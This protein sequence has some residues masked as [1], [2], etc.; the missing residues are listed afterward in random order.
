MKLFSSEQVRSLDQKTASQEQ[1]SSSILMEHAGLEAAGT[2][3]EVLKGVR[4]KTIAVLCGP[5]NNGGDGLVAARTLLDWGAVVVVYFVADPK[6]LSGECKSNYD[7]LKNLKS[8][9]FIEQAT[10]QKQLENADCVVDALF[11]TGLKKPVEGVFA[12]AISA[13]NLSGKTVVSVDLPSGVDADTGKILGTAVKATYTVTLA[14]PKLGLYLYPARALVGNLRTAYI[15]IP[16]SLIESS[17]C[18]AELATPKEVAAWLPAWKADIHKGE[19]GRVM[20]L[21]GSRGYSGAPA[22]ASMAALHTGSGL[23]YLGIPDGIRALMEHK[24]TEVIKIGIPQTNNWVFG[25]PSL[26]ETRRWFDKIDALAIGPGIGRTDETQEFVKT[27]IQDYQGPLVVDADALFALNEDFLKANGRSQIVLTPHEGEMGRLCGIP[28]EKVRENRYELAREKAKAWNVTL[29][30]KG[31][32]TLIVSGDSVWVNSTGNPGMATAGSG[33]VLTGI[34]VSLL[35]QGMSP[36]KA[37]VAGAF[38]HGLSG[39]LLAQELGLHAIT[40]E[41]LSSNLPKAFHSL[42]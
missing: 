23:V 16:T 11:G 20:I 3:L 21:G 10:F 2:V 25:K 32:S 6:K 40:A 12:D 9:I 31:A 7:I 22:L 13:V 18:A 35:G 34:I 29:L 5:G 14:V 1:I 19:R 4:G 42:P 38:L 36:E 24:L 26:P 39:D 37:A 30:L 15:G 28:A 17:P 8:N 27:V 33:D 41:A